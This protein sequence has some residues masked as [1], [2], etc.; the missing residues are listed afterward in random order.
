MY[1]FNL[2]LSSCVKSLFRKKYTMYT[3]NLGGET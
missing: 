1:F 3:I 2:T